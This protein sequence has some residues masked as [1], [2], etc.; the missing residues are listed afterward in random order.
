MLF[1]ITIMIMNT[2]PSAPHCQCTSRQQ[3]RQQPSC[4]P[5]GQSVAGLVKHQVESRQTSVALSDHIP[6]P[7]NAL[8]KVSWLVIGG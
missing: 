8:A 6:H 7:W 5:S 3:T 2:T 4:A 1:A